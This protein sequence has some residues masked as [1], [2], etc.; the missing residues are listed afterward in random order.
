[1]GFFYHV[2]IN[3]KEGS[4]GITL[5]EAVRSTGIQGTMDDKLFATLV[6]TSF[7]QLSGIL[8]L[9]EFFGPSYNILLAPKRFVSRL[10]TRKINDGSD[11]VEKSEGDG[12]ENLAVDKEQ[13]R[14][15]KT[16]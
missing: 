12:E 7:M 11:K 1:M 9:P 13:T 16:A 14:K 4:M 15:K 10:T 2:F 6:V 8:M 5:R 3:D